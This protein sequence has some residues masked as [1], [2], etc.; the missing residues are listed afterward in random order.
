MKKY[1]ECKGCQQST[2][3]GAMEGYA[4]RNKVAVSQIACI[5]CLKDRNYHAKT[6]ACESHTEKAER[7]VE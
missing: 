6:H 5:F 3:T 1:K 4:E 7:L 2:T